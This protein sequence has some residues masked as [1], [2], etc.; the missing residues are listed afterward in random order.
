M[1]EEFL[2][3]IPFIDAVFRQI[4]VRFAVFRFLLEGLQFARLRILRDERIV[5]QHRR[6][7]VAKKNHSIAPYLENSFTW[8]LADEI[9]FVSFF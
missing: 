2:V 1:D 6:L 3:R 8:E 7:L 5:I 4:I 9:S